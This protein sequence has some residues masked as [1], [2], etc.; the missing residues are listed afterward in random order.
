[1]PWYLR[2]S[3]WSYQSFWHQQSSQATDLKDESSSEDGHSATPIREITK[4]PSSRRDVESS[5]GHNTEVSRFD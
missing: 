4:L 1:M 5:G 2:A 3:K